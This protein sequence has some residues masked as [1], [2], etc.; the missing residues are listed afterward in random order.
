MDGETTNWRSLKLELTTKNLEKYFDRLW[1][2][3]RSIT[4]NGL[5]ES[6]SI[7]KEIIPLELIEIPTGQKILDWEIP[8]EW[9][10]R[11]AY[12]IA[13]NGE[14]IVDFKK[15]NLHVVNYSIPVDKEIEL[16]ELQDYLHSYEHLPNAIPYITSYYKEQ[17]GFCLTHNQR[18]SLHPGKYKVVVDSNLSDGA[19]TYGT[20]LLSSTSGNDQEILLSSYLC[21][22]S[23]ANNELSGPLATSFLYNQLAKK[24]E[25]LFNYRFVIAPETIGIISFLSDWGEHLKRNL[26]GGYVITCCG[27]NKQYTYK[28]SKNDD[29]EIDRVAIQYLNKYVKEKSAELKIYDFFPLGSDERQYCSPGYNFNVGSIMRSM[30]GNYKEY[31]TSLDNKDFISFE[32]MKETIK[33]YLNVLES[34]ENNKTFVNLVGCGEPQLGKYD[35]YPS[36]GG[37]VNNQKVQRFVLLMNYVLSYS[38][39]KHDLL[40]IAEKADSSIVELYPIVMRLKEKG[41]LKDVKTVS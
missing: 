8:K 15:N 22:P 38:D 28:K 3:C 2:I 21:H 25:R 33:I 26:F 14:K 31:H 32:G 13:P 11:D 36:F 40:S 39:G 34:L 7:L 19:L 29:S 1:P 10:I 37:T 17:W 9:N 12:I 30:Y 27:D 35:L 41:L 18:S 24:E 6:F 4:G 5:R 16:D 23:L 20:C